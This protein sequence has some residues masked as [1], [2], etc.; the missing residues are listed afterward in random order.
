MRLMGSCRFSPDIVSFMNNEEGSMNNSQIPK[1]G[2]SGGHFII[3]DK[4]SA[5][6]AAAVLLYGVRVP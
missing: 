1:H 6:P 3:S 5:N 4:T 2:R